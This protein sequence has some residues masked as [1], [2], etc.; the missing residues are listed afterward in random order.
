VKFLIS[1]VLDLFKKP[2]EEFTPW[3]LP[4]PV[5]AQRKRAVKKPVTKKIVAKKTTRKKAAK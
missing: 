1:W 2:E 4:A 3:P 5:K